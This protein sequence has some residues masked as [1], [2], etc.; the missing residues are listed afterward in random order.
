MFPD[1][2]RQGTSFPQLYAPHE[3]G[4]AFSNGYLYCRKVRRSS[5]RSVHPCLDT[6]QDAARRAIPHVPCRHLRD[7]MLNIP[8]R[9]STSA[10]VCYCCLLVQYS[11][12]QTV[13]TA[14]SFH[15]LTLTPLIILSFI[16]KDLNYYLKASK[17]SFCKIIDFETSNF[18]QM[19]RFMII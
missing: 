9:Q 5:W 4:F 11:C 8:I 7:E 10:T 6:I 15:F 19:H 3:V 1:L 14:P 2:S 17:I 16:T 13:L 18:H 12:E